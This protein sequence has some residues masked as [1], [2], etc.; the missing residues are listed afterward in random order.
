MR[1]LFAFA[2]EQFLEDSVRQLSVEI[3]QYEAAATVEWMGREMTFQDLTVAITTEPVR[4]ARRAIYR[5]RLAVI[6]ASNGLRAE[7]LLKLHESACSLGYLSYMELFEQLRQLDY[8][9]IAWQAATLLSS[10]ELK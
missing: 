1:R 3:G 7:P 8:S 5:G 10:T 9:E 2:V 6:E 4:E